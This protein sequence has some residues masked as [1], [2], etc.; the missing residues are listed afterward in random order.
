ME[1]RREA[2]QE[3]RTAIMIVD[4]HALFCEGLRRIIDAELDM[5][6]VGAATSGLD[7]VRQARHLR[8]DV[9]L[10]N[11]KM[12]DCDGLTSMRAI[13]RTARAK[14]IV[15]SAH[16]ETH[17]MSRALKAGAAGY[18]EKSL[19]GPQ[20]ISV[21]R[22]VLRGSV[23]LS[24]TA[25]KFLVSPPSPANAVE[26]TS[27]LSELTPRERQIMVMIAEGRSVA[28]TA[29][30]LGLTARTVHTHRKNILVKLGLRTTTE[31]IGFAF[32]QGIVNVDSTYLLQRSDVI[33]RFLWINLTMNA[34][35]WL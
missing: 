24:A 35:N 9:V 26:A 34:L 8:P 29:Q 31:M 11:D 30:V 5:E 3:K 15:L 2:L 19:N 33:L 18:V 25:A 20:L 10:I 6:I 7:A 32:R 21:I 27:L 17:V 4:D 28:S 22:S 13:L 16:I 23:V 12:P 14:T 1:S